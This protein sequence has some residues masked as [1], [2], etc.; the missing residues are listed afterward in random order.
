M[1]RQLTCT[2]LDLT[3]QPPTHPERPDSA[4]PPTLPPFLQLLAVPVGL[5][6]GRL[7]VSGP[8]RQPPVAPVVPLLERATVTHE[9]PGHRVAWCTKLLR[10]NECS[11]VHYPHGE[12]TKRLEVYVVILPLY[13][14]QWNTFL[15]AGAGP[16]LVAA[17]C[18]IATHWTQARRPLAAL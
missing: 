10:V 7:P 16:G 12:Y 17:T 14:R 18:R 15:S 2:Q 1:V 5:A 9:R 13:R 8:R 6:A 11:V 4:N 3:L